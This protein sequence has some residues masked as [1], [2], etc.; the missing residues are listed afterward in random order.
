MKVWCILLCCVVTR[1]FSQDYVVVGDTL[2]QGQVRRSGSEKITL[3][4]G[5]TLVEY[6]MAKVSEY[7][8]GS[9]IYQSLVVH[10]DRL[11]YK[12]VASGKINLYK[13][14]RR[15]LL[16]SDDQLVELHKS[17]FRSTLKSS[18][19]CYGKEGG[20]SKVVFSRPS[21][22]GVVEASNS[23]S[24]NL[25]QI[26]Y[27]KFGLAIAYGFDNLKASATQTI[28]SS[29]PQR[30]LFSELFFEAPLFVR[31]PWLYGSAEFFISI[32]SEAEFVFH[33][34]N[35]VTHM[36]TKMQT[37]LLTPGFKLTTIKG[38]VR[39]YLKLAPAISYTHFESPT[40]LRVKGSFR[41]GQLVTSVAPDSYPQIGLSG[42]AGI[43]WEV[44]GR[45]NLHFEI[46]HLSAASNSNTQF[47]VSSKST[48]ILL[49]AS[50]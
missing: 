14:G 27:R 6:P 4:Y 5:S 16:K 34:P 11:M 40:G 22:Q 46:R 1:A 36:T 38:S 2:K 31:F 10:G 12:R 9:S 37:L 43:Q 50:F 35:Q 13:K 18:L 17:D 33:E 19:S 45:T 26:A 21:L 8:Q 48:V 32:P 42:A 3:G 28:H 44:V 39:P 24:C 49:G 7:R 47:E 15:Y 20:I 41:D 23:G 25:D 30:S 29:A